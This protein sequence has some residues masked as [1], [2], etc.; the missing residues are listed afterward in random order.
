M[1]ITVADLGIEK[2]GFKVGEG[3]LP[4]SG[5]PR[6][7]SSIGGSGGMPPQKIFGN[8]DALRC[9][10]AHSGVKTESLLEVK[11]PDM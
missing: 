11:D 6:Q 3:H 9:N 8:M 7:R 1:I 2:G 10:L 5:P 4:R